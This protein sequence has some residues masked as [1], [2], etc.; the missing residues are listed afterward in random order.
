MA[1]NQTESPTTEPDQGT[2]CA[3][4]GK[5]ASRTC[6][7]C[8]GAPEYKPGDAT[9]TVICSTDCLRDLWQTH[10][11]RCGMMQK[12]IKLRRLAYLMKE[13]AKAYRECVFYQNLQGVELRHGTLYFD[14]NSFGNPNLG[15]F[16]ETLTSDKDIKESVV[17]NNQCM[18]V[19]YLLAP[20]ASQF[21]PAAK[22]DTARKLNVMVDP[23]IPYRVVGGDDWEPLHTILEVHMGEEQWIL[24]LSGRQYGYPEILEPLDEYVKSKI[25]GGTLE[26]SAIDE[27]YDT[28][29]GTGDLDE[30][31]GT[32]PVNRR[33]V[34]LQA[35]IMARRHFIRFARCRF[36]EGSAREFLSGN[37]QVFEGRVESFVEEIKTLMTGFMNEYNREERAVPTCVL[38]PPTTDK[39]AIPSSNVE[40]APAV[41]DLQKALQ[42]EPQPPPQKKPIPQGQGHRSRSRSQKMKWK[43]RK[44]KEKEKL[45]K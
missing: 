9:E 23:V 36:N 40:F 6:P 14:F 1:D 33:T 44:K 17:F 2:R 25:R 5:E 8:A 30:M 35:D 7:G 18:A 13:S 15:P 21:F 4:C 31:W 19:L 16:P 3:N 32:L 29:D 10:R 27:E 38:Q 41:E 42:E 37:A 20:L 11:F 26:P 45:E 34:R 22:I 28:D 43:N 39:D 24:D 12:R